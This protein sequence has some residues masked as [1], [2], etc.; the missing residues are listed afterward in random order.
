MTSAGPNSVP[1]ANEAQFE[2]LPLV[3]TVDEAARVLRIGRSAAY[4]QTAVYLRTGGTEGL[5]VVRLGRSLRVPRHELGRLLGIGADATG[6][7]SDEPLGRGHAI[8]DPKGDTSRTDR[9]TQ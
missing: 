6:S 3:L 2:M 1:M 8:P 7:G 4:E 9:G 5:P